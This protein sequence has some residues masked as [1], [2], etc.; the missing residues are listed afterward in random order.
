MKIIYGPGAYAAICI[1][2]MH[3][4]YGYMYQRRC[5]MRADHK[6]FGAVTENMC[7]RSALCAGCG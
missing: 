5:S 6:P 1:Y 2:S 4:L 7:W 3:V